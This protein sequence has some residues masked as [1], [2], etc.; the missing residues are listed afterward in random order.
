MHEHMQVPEAHRSGWWR[1]RVSHDDYPTV[2]LLESVGALSLHG[3]YLGFASS[4][5]ANGIHIT[6]VSIP[7]VG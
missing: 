2:S 3:L 1:K 7:L 5:M 4:P 6:L